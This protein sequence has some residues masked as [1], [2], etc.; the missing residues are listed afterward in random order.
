[1]AVCKSNLLLLIA[2][3]F[4]GCGAGL[5]HPIVNTAA[6]KDSGK[7]GRGTATSTFMMSQDLGMTIG[8]FL[9]GTISGTYGFSRVYTTVVLLLFVMMY[10]FRKF[11]AS[12]IN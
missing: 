4:Y 1:M 3:A 7:A 8:A 10:V 11:L 5:I 9:W 2:A 6:V 12:K